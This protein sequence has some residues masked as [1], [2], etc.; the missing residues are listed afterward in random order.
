M[1]RSRGGI[2]GSQAGDSRD[3]E[4]PPPLAQC[5]DHLAEQL[6]RLRPISFGMVQPR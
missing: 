6:G 5:A 3:A 2:V 1:T 4:G